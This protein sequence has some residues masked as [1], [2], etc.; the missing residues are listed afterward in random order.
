MSNGDD[1][2]QQERARQKAFLDQNL[3]WP[4]DYLFKFIIADA[5]R[6]EFEIIFPEL[7]NTGYS[8]KPSSNGNYISITFTLRMNTSDEVLAIYARAKFIKGLIA[9]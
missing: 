9:L 5:K 1:K 6:N 4:T 2:E 7:K 3:T 8:T